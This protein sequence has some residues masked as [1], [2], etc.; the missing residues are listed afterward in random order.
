MI[1]L[2]QYDQRWSN[3]K[4]LPSNLTLGRYGCTTTSICMLSDY[5]KCF[6]IPSQA[7][8]HNIKYTKD[9]LIIWQSI[10][11][12]KFEFS[13]RY[14]QFSQP[15]IDECL[16][17]PLKAVIFNINGGAHWVT[18]ISK[19][20]FGYYKVYDPWGGKVRIIKAKEIVGFATFQSK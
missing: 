16:K 19:L 1:L 12:D 20:P 3:I 14:R 18:G 17:N 13:G 9:G 8:D 4:M 15:V 5:F 7:V 10:K 6:V 11:F 2:N